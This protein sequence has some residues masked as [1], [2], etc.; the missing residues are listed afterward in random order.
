MLSVRSTN[1]AARCPH[2][3]LHP[4][5]L[6]WRGVTVYSYQAMIYFGLTSCLMLLDVMSRAVGLD[7]FRCIA[8]AIVLASVG[9]IGARLWF[10]AAHWD[11][12]RRRPASI[13]KRDEGGAAIVGGLVI[14]IVVSPLILI[15]LKLPLGPFWDAAIVG[16]LVWSMFG[17]VGCLLHGC[18]SGRPSG[19]LLALPL[20][21]HRGERQR[22][23]PTQLLEF[24]LCGCILAA[25]AALWAYRP[26]PGAL[27][28][29][30]LAIYGLGRAALLPLR[31]DYHRA[32]GSALYQGVAAAGALVALGAL[33]ALW[34]T[35]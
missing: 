27:F 35:T 9:L 7:P 13:W 24:L 19:G 30:C 3:G 5:L 32:S 22:R 15:P 21:N 2:G 16:M 28:L 10:V 1:A 34:H 31:E 33:T 17:R 20:P 26:F 11:Y 29:M 25:A 18:C 6:Q 8:A 23:M 4:I 12:Y 14:S